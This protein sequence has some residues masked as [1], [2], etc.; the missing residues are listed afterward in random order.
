MAEREGRFEGSAHDRQDGFLH[1]STAAQL[2]ET[3]ARH[4]AGT[5]ELLLL[6]VDETELGPALKWE[7]SVSR[8]ERFPHLYGALCVSAVK[9]KYL[10]V[11]D[12]QGRHVVP[13]MASAP[14]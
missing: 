14:P 13:A 1:F 6:A 10:L 3:L 11:R 5:D 2:A 8:G 4:Y 7:I 12:E 9:W